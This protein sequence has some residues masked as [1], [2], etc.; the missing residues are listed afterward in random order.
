MYSLSNNY[1]KKQIN[2]IDQLVIKAYKIGH[3]HYDFLLKWKVE[4]LEAI[5]N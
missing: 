5:K 4:H 2:N 3:K 1:H